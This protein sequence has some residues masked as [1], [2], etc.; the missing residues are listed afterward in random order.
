MVGLPPAYCGFTMRALPTELNASSSVVK[1]LPTCAP[2]LG[3]SFPRSPSSGRIWMSSPVCGVAVSKTM[4]R[5]SGAH[6]R[7][8]FFITPEA[9]SSSSWPLP[10]TGR[11]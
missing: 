4:E 6:D 5:P 9:W 1:K 3:D 2:D 10:V 7:G 8:H 11:G